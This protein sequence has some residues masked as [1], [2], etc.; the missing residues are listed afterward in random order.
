MPPP[1]VYT[2]VGR[3]G[4]NEITLKVFDAI[5]RILH[6]E[7]QATLLLTGPGQ[8]VPVTPVTLLAYHSGAQPRLF[9]FFFYHGTPA[10]DLDASPRI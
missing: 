9:S 7:F 6:R 4:E 5:N 10:M 2:L 1:S 8:P 3:A